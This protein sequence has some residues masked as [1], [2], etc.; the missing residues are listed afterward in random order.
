M[1]S[2][3]LGIAASLLAAFLYQ[4]F[5]RNQRARKLKKRYSHLTGLYANY[6]IQNGGR[7]NRWQHQTRSAT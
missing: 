6:R 2:F 7:A 5:L 1:M 4:E 3:I